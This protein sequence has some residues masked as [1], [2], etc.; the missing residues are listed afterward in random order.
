MRRSDGGRLF[1]VDGAATEN[2][3]WPRLVLVLTTVAAPLVAERRRLLLQSAFA[4]WTKSQRCGGQSWRCTLWTRVAIL[5][6][7]RW[8]T[9]SQRSFFKAGVIWA[10]RF[11]PRT[12]RATV[13]WTCCSGAIADAERLTS[14]RVV[15]L[16]SWTWTQVGL[17]SDFLRTWTGLGLEGQG[18][19]LGLGLERWGLGTGTLNYWNR[20]GGKI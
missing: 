9:G 14:T 2:A 7:I 5:N 13:F 18:L 1:H 16:E 8:R 20:C 6:V 12:R 10:L 19:G 4:K 17:E 15:G 3:R 11:I